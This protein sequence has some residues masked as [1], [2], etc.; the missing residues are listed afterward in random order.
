MTQLSA[1][2]SSCAK[3]LL[4]FTVMFII[5]FISFAQFGYLVFG[6]Q[7]ES[8]STFNFAVWVKVFTVYFGICWK[9]T[10]SDDFCSFDDGVIYAHTNAELVVVFLQLEHHSTAT[11]KI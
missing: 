8:Y 1:T 10:Y 11:F 2:M 6:T 7:V 5:V 4:A 9:L 3:D